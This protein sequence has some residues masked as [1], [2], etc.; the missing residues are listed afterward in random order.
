MHPI[1]LELI[2]LIVDLNPD[3]CMLWFALVKISGM[4]H[5]WKKGFGWSNITLINSSPS[6]SPSN[7]ILEGSLSFLCKATI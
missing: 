6:L 7:N 3:C 4:D 5:C 1:D 2:K